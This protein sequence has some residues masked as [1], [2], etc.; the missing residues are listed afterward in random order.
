MSPEVSE[1]AARRNLAKIDHVIVLMMENRS[2]DHVLGY[3]KLEG[4]RPDVDGLEAG[5]GNEDAA[6]KFHRVRPLG[7]RRIDLNALDPGHGPADVRE[8]ISGG[9]AGFLRN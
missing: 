3:L 9:M 5:M 2:F 8:Q 4:V 1:D 6:G 7:R